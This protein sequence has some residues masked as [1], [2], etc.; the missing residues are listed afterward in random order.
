LDILRE[1]CERFLFVGRGR[2]E[3]LADFDALVA[4]ADVRRYL[5]GLSP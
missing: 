2:C 1:I 5:G 3:A 4:N